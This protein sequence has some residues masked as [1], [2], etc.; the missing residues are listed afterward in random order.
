MTIAEHA[1][2]ILDLKE[3]DLPE[4]P[5]IVGIDVEEFLDHDGDDAL[6]VYLYLDESTRDSELKGEAMIAI[7]MAVQKK[8][9]ESGFKEYPYT[10][11]SKWS[12]FHPNEIEGADTNA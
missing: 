1:K 9:F 2:Q 4:S 10:Q 5:K 6:R 12:E 11:I 7:R 8:L 3:L